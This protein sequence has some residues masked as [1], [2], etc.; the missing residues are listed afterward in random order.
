M[1]R[2]RT[3]SPRRPV[4]PTAAVVTALLLLAAV[5]VAAG[6]LGAAIAQSAL[7]A[8]AAP[9]ASA[10]D[11]TSGV[12]VVEPGGALGAPGRTESQPVGQAS[13]LGLAD[14]L[15]PG[16]VTVFD[17]GYPAV[18]NL[19]PDLL[20]TLQAAVTTGGLDLYVTSGWRSEAYQ[21]QLLADAIDTYGSEAE[22]ARWVAPA[23]KSLHVAGQAVDLTGD[24]ALEWLAEHGSAFGLCQIYDN[25]PW[26]YELRLNAPAEGCPSRYPDASWDPRLR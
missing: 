11:Q 17:S 20:Q 5:A 7:S 8:V 24:G 4:S 6:C 25:E 16:G 23:D 14:G 18:A 26:H 10:S 13:R 1:S 2:T 12:S 22:A 19:D 9:P 21:K 15:L 3:S